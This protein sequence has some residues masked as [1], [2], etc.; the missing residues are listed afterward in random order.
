[1]VGLRL[2]AVVVRSSAQ[3]GSHFPRQSNTHVSCYRV[4]S[5]QQ[6]AIVRQAHLRS[7]SSDAFACRKHPQGRRPSVTNVLLSCVFRQSAQLCRHAIASFLFDWCLNS[8][9]LAHHRAG[10][11]I[12]APIDGGGE[13][14]SK[15]STAPL[16][17]LQEGWLQKR[18]RFTQQWHWRCPRVTGLFSLLASLAG[19]RFRRHALMPMGPEATPC[20]AC[21]RR[22]HHTSKELHASVRA[23]LEELKGG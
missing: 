13:A 4:A 11:G 16:Y 9:V 7:L 1:M 2:S 3:I 8:S 21:V 6:L 22:L 10:G 19:C 5:A 20:T 23:S 12:P 14:G 18:G 17:T 15:I